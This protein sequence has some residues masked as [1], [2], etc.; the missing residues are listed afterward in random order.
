LQKANT[1]QHDK[2]ILTLTAGM[3]GLTITFISNIAPNPPPWTMIFLASGWGGLVLSMVAMLCSFLTGQWACEDQI[4]LL[5]QHAAKGIRPEQKNYWSK[6]T[7]LLNTSSLALF[8][9]G[10]ILVAIFSGI[11]LLARTPAAAKSQQPPA[12]GPN[13]LADTPKVVPLTVPGQ[14]S[15]ATP[16]PGSGHTP[17]SSPPVTPAAPPPSSPPTKK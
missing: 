8:I 16:N 3:L 14:P 7:K 17:P 4:K 11:N 2:A 5:D 12:Q 6:W 1:D 15:P 13:D 9:V 10:I